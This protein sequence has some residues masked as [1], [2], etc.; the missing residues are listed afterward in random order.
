MRAN[1]SLNLRERCFPRLLALPPTSEPR[2]LARRRPVARCS[3]QSFRRARYPWTKNEIVVTRRGQLSSSIAPARGCG[4]LC[5]RGPR[6][7]RERRWR[8]RACSPDSKREKPNCLPRKKRRN[9]LSTG[10]S[11]FSIMI[12]PQVH[13]RKPCYDFYFL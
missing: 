5:E 12:L 6:R 7:S 1:S 10:R 13:L 11:F 4:A 8:L 3:R 2:P 9:G